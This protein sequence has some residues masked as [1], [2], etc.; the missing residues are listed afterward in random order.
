MLLVAASIEGF[1]SGWVLPDWVKAVFA[2][3]QVVLVV[4]WLGGFA[5]RS[6]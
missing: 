3:V 4:V 2:G 6:P 5:R 1:W